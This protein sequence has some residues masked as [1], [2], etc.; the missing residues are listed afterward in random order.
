MLACW[1]GVDQ[2]TITRV[3]G[4]VRPLLARRVAR[5]TAEAVHAG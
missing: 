2:S 4:E 3:I 5:E 1:F